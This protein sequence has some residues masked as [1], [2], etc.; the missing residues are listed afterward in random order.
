M[1]Q[2]K[3]LKIVSTTLL[4]FLTII[5]SSP[6]LAQQIS[7]QS[8]QAELQKQLD[9]IQKQIDAYQQ[10]LSEIK[11]QKN[12]LQN[13]INQLK[14]QQASLNLQIQ[15][16]NL[17]IDTLDAQISD[18][19]NAIAD[20]EAKQRQL[21]GD[22]SGYVRL[23]N[24]KDKYPFL[25]VVVSK[26]NLSDA[27]SELENY[28]AIAENLRSALD[29]ARRV[30]SQLEDLT[31]NLTGQQD[32]AKNFLS[33][34]ILQQQQLKS[35]VSEQNAVLQQ[36]KG[37]EADY[38]IVLNDTQKRAGEIRSR[39]YEL[40]GI[41]GQ[42]TFGEALKIAQLASQA[43]GV[44]PAFLL[45]IL[46]Q[47]SNL[48]KNVGTCNRLGDPPEKS[49]TVVMKPDRDQQ[50]FLQ[51]TGE[52][53]LDPNITP[54]SCPMRDKRG[55]QIGWGGA[56][57]PAQFI[58]STWMGYKDKVAQFT[59]KAVANPW[60]IRDAFLAAAIKLKAGGADGTRQGEWDAAMR[61][62]SGGTNTRY[63]FYGDNVLVLADK[64]QTDI[65]ALK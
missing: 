41:S 2:N 40:L 43:T 57:G 58:P 21:Q 8:T 65:D 33:V 20:N 9:E 28:A 17:K 63:R 46:T 4:V 31:Q 45:A 11:G 12:T 24:Q 23:I 30:K 26:G 34:K 38:Q 3:L 62:F 6:S 16:T 10:Q 25:Y 61:Y 60:D 7:T 37:R 50:P 22:I 32:E 27:L 18:T 55:K 48:G 64:Y 15:A 53:G 44:R 47:E 5:L 52:L 49:W 14:K 36:T 51:I 54:V 35:S 29:Q 39:I 42:I 59:G 19:V 56:M 13:K 1:G